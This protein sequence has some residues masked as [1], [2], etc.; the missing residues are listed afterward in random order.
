MA[1]G[2]FGISF[3]RVFSGNSAQIGGLF[4]EG[5]PRLPFYTSGKVWPTQVLRARERD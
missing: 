5:F 3:W 4:L 2:D 1:E